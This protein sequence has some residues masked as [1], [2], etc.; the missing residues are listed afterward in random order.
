MTTRWTVALGGRSATATL[1]Y[2]DGQGITRIV[3]CCYTPTGI[4]RLSRM[5]EERNRS[6]VVW[7]DGK[8]IQYAERI[9]G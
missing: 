5:A 2:T 6:S 1:N 9:V 7:L 3:D 4:D 8:R